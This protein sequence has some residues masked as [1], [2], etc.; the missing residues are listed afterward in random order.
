MQ[1][2]CAENRVIQWPESEEDDIPPEGKAI[3][4][5]LLCNDPYYRLGGALMGG[6]QGV[7]QHPFFD[8]LDWDTLLRQKAEFVPSLDNEEDTSYFDSK[9]ITTIQWCLHT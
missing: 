9:C 8:D 3:V 5:E 7:K 2:N 1:F 4:E 6:V